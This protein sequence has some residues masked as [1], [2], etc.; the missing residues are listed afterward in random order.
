MRD[1]G[2]VC[3]LHEKSIGETSVLKTDLLGDTY[4]ELMRGKARSDMS[5]NEWRRKSRKI[6]HNH[7]VTHC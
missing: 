4:R 5:C 6:T 3:V 7:M 1:G 2:N